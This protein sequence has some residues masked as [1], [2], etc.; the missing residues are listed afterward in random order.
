[1]TII[2]MT[3]HAISLYNADGTA[4]LQV[5][6]ASGKTVRIAE[7][8]SPAPAVEGIPVV[9]RTYTSMEVVEGG[10]VSALP[11]PQDGVFY[12]VS[13]VVLDAARKLGGRPD[14]VSPDTGRGC[15]RDPK[16]VILGT[17]NFVV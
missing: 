9:A 1:M 5:F 11:D 8:D 16:G 10:V 14:F 2:N 3:P 7:Q 12:I 13:I 4:V 6:P 17:K 15:V